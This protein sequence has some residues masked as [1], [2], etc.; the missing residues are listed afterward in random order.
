[1]CIGFQVNGDRRLDGQQPGQLGQLGIGRQ[2]FNFF[3][4]TSVSSQIGEIDFG[5]IYTL[6]CRPANYL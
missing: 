2:N 5:C 4:A 1:L 3:H 6:P